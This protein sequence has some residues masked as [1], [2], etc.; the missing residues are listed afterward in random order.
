LGG[1]TFE[2]VFS[3]SVIALVTRPVRK[4]GKELTESGL[5]APG[6]VMKELLKCAKV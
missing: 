5:T 2:I 4:A 6:Q 1:L 3:L